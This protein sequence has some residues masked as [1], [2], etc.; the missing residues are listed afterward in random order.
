[1]TNDE[2]NRLI[3]SNSIVTIFWNAREVSNERLREKKLI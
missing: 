2:I 3:F 1:M